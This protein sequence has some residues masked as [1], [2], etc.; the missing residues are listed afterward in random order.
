MAVPDHPWSKVTRDAAA[1]RIA[2]T[3]AEAGTRGGVLREVVREDGLDSD[4]PVI[5][6]SEVSGV[7]NSDLTVGVDVSE[8]K[9]LLANQ[10][11][12]SRG[13]SLHGAGFIVTPQEAEYL[14]LGRRPRLEDHIREYRNGRDLTSRPRGVMVIDLFG[15]EVDDVRTRFP[16]VYQHIKTEV[17]E[18]I[19]V[20]KKGAREYAGRDW[21][22][23]QIIQE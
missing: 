1:V 9:P 11:L 7:I 10:G 23:R 14:G 18:K 22:H 12:S 4:A 5:E 8:C 3:V 13:M 2:M 6:L 15:L 17:K 16:E 19:V 21:N 20:N